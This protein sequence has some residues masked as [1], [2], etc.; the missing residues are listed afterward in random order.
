VALHSLAVCFSSGTKAAILLVDFCD[1]MNFRL[2]INASI[3]KETPKKSIK[4]YENTELCALVL[5]T[6]KD[7]SGVRKDQQQS[8]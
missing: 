2:S 7:V 4:V 8:V 6:V 1:P 5:R 3:G